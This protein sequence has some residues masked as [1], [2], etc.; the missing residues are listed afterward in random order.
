MFICHHYINFSICTVNFKA[1]VALL[2]LTWS[3]LQSIRGRRHGWCLG[4]A[5]RG[6]RRLGVLP[7]NHAGE[8]SFWQHIWREHGGDGGPLLFERLA[9]K[10]HLLSAVLETQHLW[11]GDGFQHCQDIH[12]E[13]T[14]VPQHQV[15]PVRRLPR[16][17][18][19]RGVPGEGIIWRALMN[20]FRSAVVLC[21][22]IWLVT[23]YMQFKFE[24]LDL[25]LAKKNLYWDN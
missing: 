13:E 15:V 6:H 21:L 11:R 20:K 5:L 25:W 14:S 10:P 18:K 23:I 8:S 17:T 2:K 3:H 16:P 9:R 24:A 12:S 22:I 7:R 19:G 4:G 1:S